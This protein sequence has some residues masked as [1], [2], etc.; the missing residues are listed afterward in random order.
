MLR[1]EKNAAI[2]KLYGKTVKIPKKWQEEIKH[3]RKIVDKVL[4]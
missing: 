3:L 2:A 4:I 1:R